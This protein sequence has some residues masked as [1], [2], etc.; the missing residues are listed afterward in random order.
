MPKLKRL[1]ISCDKYSSWNLDKLF[2]K[3]VLNLPELRAIKFQGTTYNL[4]SIFYEHFPMI[5]PA[6]QE[7]HMDINYSFMDKD[8]F[9][10]LISSRWSILEKL[11]KVYIS[12]EGKHYEIDAS[13]Q[14]KNYRKILLAKINEVNNCFKMKWTRRR[15]DYTAKLIIEK[16]NR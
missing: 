16:K 5:V 9:Q 6:L 1:K 2:C 3:S 7:L 13:K 8:M 14:M 10:T 15:K 11:E 12:I 4:S